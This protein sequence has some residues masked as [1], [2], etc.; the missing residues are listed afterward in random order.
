MV[1][2]MVNVG[3]YTILMDPMGHGRIFVVGRMRFD[4]SDFFGGW[5]SDFFQQ[6]SAVI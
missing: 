4:S 2:D 6:P 3:K 5:L 1:N